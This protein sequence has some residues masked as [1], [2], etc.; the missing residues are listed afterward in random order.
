MSLNKRVSWGKFWFPSA[1]AKRLLR[2]FLKCTVVHVFP[3]APVLIESAAYFT[4][5][6]WDVL[7]LPGVFCAHPVLYGHRSYS[8]NYP[9]A[10]GTALC[11]TRCVC[12]P[13]WCW[14]N[15]KPCVSLVQYPVLYFPSGWEKVPCTH[16]FWS[17][18]GLMLFPWQWDIANVLI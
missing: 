2:K 12:D 17:H 15:R 4:K 11:W 18:S 3:P 6:E 8:Q 10:G 13:N 5:V 16:I 14:S 7:H 1:E 9:S